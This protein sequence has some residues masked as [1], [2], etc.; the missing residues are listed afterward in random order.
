MPKLVALAAKAG[1]DAVPSDAVTL[2]LVANAADSKLLGRLQVGGGKLPDMLGGAP[3][4]VRG[5]LLGRSQALMEGHFP[6]A[7]G[8]A[9]ESPP[10]L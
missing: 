9:G 5:K 6:R 3:G 4:Q 8:R 1:G 10:P 2:R 7:C